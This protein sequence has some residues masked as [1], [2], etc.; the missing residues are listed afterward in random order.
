MEKFRHS[1][2]YLWGLWCPPRDVY[3]PLKETKYSNCDYTH[4]VWTDSNDLGSLRSPMNQF[5]VQKI[6]W[7]C[8]NLFQQNLRWWG[9]WEKIHLIFQNDVWMSYP[10]T[11]LDIS[12]GTREI[13]KYNLVVWWTTSLPAVNIFT[14]WGDDRVFIVTHC[15]NTRFTHWNRHQ[16]LVRGSDVRLYF[17]GEEYEGLHPNT[18][19]LIKNNHLYDADN[20]KIP[21]SNL[22]Y[23]SDVCVSLIGIT[24]YPFK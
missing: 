23:R 4:W 10:N 5:S 6:I 17:G 22:I 19:S 12:V 16:I 1:P 8:S 7:P 15:V 18:C 11:G 3:S 24:Y 2:C 9:Q 14:P 20:D 13:R 21:I